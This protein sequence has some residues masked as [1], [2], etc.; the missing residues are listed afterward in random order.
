MAYGGAYVGRKA[1]TA[2]VWTRFG[3][4]L[5][6]VLLQGYDGCDWAPRG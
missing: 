4:R 3:G 2:V 6:L 1:S 5:G